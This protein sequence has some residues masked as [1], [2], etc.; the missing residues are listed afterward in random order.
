MTSSSDKTAH[1]RFK[2]VD[3]KKVNLV[4]TK[5]IS[6]IVKKFKPDIII[7]FAA[8]SHV[9]KSIKN[10]E[11]FLENIIGTH[12]LLSLSLDLFKKIEN[13]NFFKFQLMR[14]LDL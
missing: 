10:S 3:F 1:K 13:L 7:N 2:N 14:Y 6:K 12:N 8:H 4:Q 11:I 9:D 5:K